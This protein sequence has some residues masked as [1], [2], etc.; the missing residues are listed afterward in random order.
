ME[1]IR[2]YTFGEFQKLMRRLTDDNTLRLHDGRKYCDSEIWAESKNKT[3]GY[4]T[5]RD[6]ITILCRHFYPNE[7]DRFYYLA[8]L[9][10]GMIGL[11]KKESRL[12]EHIYPVVRKKTRSGNVKKT[13]ENFRCQKVKK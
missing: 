12:P 11:L 4:Y 3:C 9:D 5:D 8:I 7:F 1:I 6:M 10:D 2:V 13:C